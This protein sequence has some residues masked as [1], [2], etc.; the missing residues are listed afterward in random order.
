M[1]KSRP[2]IALA[3][4]GM[5]LFL[6][7]PRVIHSQGD[8]TVAGARRYAQFCSACHG[9]DGKGGDKA[10]AL[11]TNPDVMSRSDTELFRIVHDGTPQGMP[12][13]A[14]IGDANLAAVIHFIRSLQETGG[15]SGKMQRAA[16]GDP[17]AGQSLFF[18][19]A[20]CSGCHMMQGKGGF[21]AGN[22]TSYARNRN[23]NAILQAIIRPDSPLQRSSRVVSVT[24]K[25]GQSITG[26]LRNED[27]FSLVIQTE[28]GRYHFLSRS[29]LT[30]ISYTE[31]SLMP[32]D[33]GTRLSPVELGDIVSFLM[34]SGNNP[35]ATEEPAR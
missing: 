4:C 18:G 22:L 13:F 14:Q 24:M 6:F 2:K 8:S 27:N 28:D 5:L 3:I 10:T 19:K 25:D 31:H 12:P 34:A 30:K 11:A 26:A 16:S 29:G 7:S 15:S 20:Q 21:M 35:P 32:N 23:P 33:Y 9:A 17:A 1:S